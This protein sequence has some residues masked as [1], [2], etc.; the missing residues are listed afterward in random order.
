MTAWR[1]L[2]APFLRGLR[3]PRNPRHHAAPRRKKDRRRPEREGTNCS[4]HPS[5]PLAVSLHLLPLH[6]SSSASLSLLSLSPLSLHLC[7]SVCLSVHLSFSV[8]IGFSFLPL[9]L[10]YTDGFVICLKGS[11]IFFFLLFPFLFAF[12]MDSISSPFSAFEIHRLH[13][14]SRCLSRPFSAFTGL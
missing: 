6:F 4:V 1:W 5:P 2:V 11:V 14:G 9:S 3:A 8:S 7:L 10:S 12:I 13:D